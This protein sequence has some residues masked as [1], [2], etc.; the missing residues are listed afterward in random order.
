MICACVCSALLDSLETPWTV[1]H[2]SPLSMKFSRKNTGVGCQ[3]L[4]GD[5][6]DPEIKCASPALTGGFFTAVPPGQPYMI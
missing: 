6:P 5:F 2:Q 3:F 4:P 1:A